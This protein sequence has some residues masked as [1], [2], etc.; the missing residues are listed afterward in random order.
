[1]AHNSV[2]HHLVWVQIQKKA[3]KWWKEKREDY[4]DFE[5]KANTMARENEEVELARSRKMKK[6]G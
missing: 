4:A 6:M 3:A 2:V 5:E 1:M